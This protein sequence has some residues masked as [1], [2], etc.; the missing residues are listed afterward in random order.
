MRQLMLTLLIAY[1]PAAA[2]AGRFEFHAAV[3]SGAWARIL[4]TIAWTPGPA[5]SASLLVLGDGTAVSPALSTLVERGSILVLQGESPAAESFGFRGSSE[6]IH[7]G[8]IVEAR[9]PSLAIFWQVPVELPRFAVPRAA[10][11]FAKER[12]TGA[13]VLAGFRRG[14]GAVLWMIAGPGEEGSERFPYLLQALVDLGLEA[15][16][17]SSRLWAF[18]D[19][20]YRLR[21]DVDF[22][23]KRWREA[24]ISAL[25]VAAWHYMEPDAGRDEY[26]RSLIEACHRNGVL[27][28]A[29]LEL[30]HV[31]EKFWNDHPEWREKTAILEDAAL[32][33]RKLMNLANRDCSQAVLVAVNS[34]L[35]RYDWD[36]VNLAELYFESLEGAANPSRFTP[37]SQEVRTEFRALHGLDPAGLFSQR[38]D[39]E[40]LRLFLEYRAGLAQR[41]Q[42]EWLGHVERL[43]SRLPHLD[44]VLTHVDDQFETRMKEAI[45]ADAARVLPLMKRQQFTFLVEDPATIWDRGPQRYPEI[46]RRYD[47]LTPDRERLGVDINIVERYQDVYPTKQQTGTELFRLVHLA[48]GAFARVALYFE[49]S[50]LGPDLPLLPAAASAVLEWER[51]GDGWYVNSAHGVGVVWKDGAKVDGRL[52]PVRNERVLW[53]PA[54]AHSVVGTEEVPSVRVMEFNGGLLGAEVRSDGATVVRYQGASRSLALLD[55]RPSSVLLDGRPEGFR[56][57]GDRT[58]LLPPGR[59]EVVIRVDGQDRADYN[60]PRQ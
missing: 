8:G 2:V 56:F 58:L 20:S 18:F 42:E 11:L 51:R 50:I 39:V 3:D 38:R 32:D 30:P 29:W 24:G 14:A 40:A 15:P 35:I 49:Y 5:D 57:E 54:G 46:A 53:L 17:R 41:I 13:P 60:K 44:V 37:M 36:G 25:H 1:A 33:W 22:L 28:Y 4:S 21:A 9:Q 43:R 55:R 19:S 59:H 48:S 27:V 26:L 52:W 31:S 6:R 45:G 16:F 12:R 10:R 23:A 7:V 47:S 34:L